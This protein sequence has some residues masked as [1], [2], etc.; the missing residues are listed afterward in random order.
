[1]RD[2]FRLNNFDLLRLGPSNAVALVN[3][4][5]R[6]ALTAALP[7]AIAKCVSPTPGGTKSRRFSACAMKRPVESS[8]TILVSTE[9]WSLKSNS[10][11]A[12]AAGKCAFCIPIAT[13][14]R[15]FEATSVRRTVSRNAR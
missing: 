11:S 1:M 12:F 14:L 6:P 15:C 5:E 3:S 10:S 4:T 9:G 8:R 2:T 13:R 7:S